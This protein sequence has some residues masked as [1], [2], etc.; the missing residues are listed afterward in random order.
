MDDHSA[1]EKVQSILPEMSENGKLELYQTLGDSLY[2]GVR[3]GGKYTYGIFS[4][5]NIREF[6]VNDFYHIHAIY[7]YLDKIDC[8]DN[9]QIMFINSGDDDIVK[10]NCA[11]MSNDKDSLIE[12][13]EARLVHDTLHKKKKKTG[14]PITDWS[15]VVRFR[16]DLYNDDGEHFLIGQE[17]GHTGELIGHGDISYIKLFSE[18]IE[19]SK[20]CNEFKASCEFEDL[21]TSIIINGEK[22]QVL[23]RRFECEGTDGG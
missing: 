6:L 7:K 1:V 14:E 15:I 5:C 10:F 16:N 13:P 9:F 23:Y 8:G 22:C 3:L 12:H 17:Y 20:H 18:A 19:H 21:E 4:I 2:G 11:R